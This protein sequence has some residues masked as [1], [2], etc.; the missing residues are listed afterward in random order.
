MADEAAADATAI[1]ADATAIPAELA[2]GAKIRVNGLNARPEF[3]GTTG[4]TVSWDSAKGRVGIKLDD[5][6]EKLSLKPANLEVLETA[7]EVKAKQKQMF[8]SM[9]SKP[10]SLSSRDADVVW[11]GTVLPKV[12][13]DIEVDGKPMG[14]ILIE[15]WPHKAPK[16]AE[17]FRALCTG[18]RGLSKR[19][20]KRLC[21][22]GSKISHCIADAGIMAGVINTTT[23]N[24][25][26]GESIYGDDYED[27]SFQA[28]DAPKHDRP[29]L[30]CM[31]WMGDKPPGWDPQDK[32]P[33]KRMSLAFGSRFTINIGVE[34]G[35]NGFLPVIGAVVEGM[36]VVQAVSETP[37]DSKHRPENMD[38][39]PID[40]VI[41][42][43]GEV[44]QALTPVGPRPP[45]PPRVQEVST[46][47]G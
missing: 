37:G 21:Y 10:G 31:G 34:P 16:S 6:G 33:N 20:R 19:T 28:D 39:V 35:F 40:V 43:C 42:D 47:E 17:N 44:A 13:L 11:T 29:G 2:T 46:S 22:K 45:S 9:F 32:D 30:V 12:F 24:K 38:G 41:A 14:R 4:T 18:E 5:S 1:P 15:L 36:D 27:L 25:R 8:A 23:G 7:A 26:G 3:N